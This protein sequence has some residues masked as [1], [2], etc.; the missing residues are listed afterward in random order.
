MLEELEF[1]Q[2]IRTRGWS[3]RFH[4]FN[5]SLILL[6]IF[7]S[8]YL[9]TAFGREICRYFAF[10]FIGAVVQTHFGM[11]AVA[12]FFSSSTICECNSPQRSLIYISEKTHG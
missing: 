12:D 1:W 9:H 2:G 7:G 11:S 10:E 8:F 5:F 3:L 4:L 6:S